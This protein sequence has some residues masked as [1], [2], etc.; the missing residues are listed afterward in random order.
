MGRLSG[1]QT[2]LLDLDGTLY[3]GS[4]VVP[5]APE[6]VR[7]L[8][9]RGLTV[10][11]TTNTDSITPAALA[12]HLA[13]LGFPAT[14]DELVT[15]V[16]VAARLLASGPQARVL[17]VAA[18]GVR[19]LLAGCLAGPDEP[20]THVLVADPS[21]GAT[22]QD[23]DAAFRAVRAG[24]EL[25]AT[26]VNRIARRD[27]GEHL[28]T[29]GWVRLLEY[30]SGQSARVLGKPS[31]A[32]FTAPLDALGRGPDTALVVGD[33]LAADVGGGQAIG[34]ATVLVRSGKGDRPQPGAEAEPDAVL[35]S[36]ADLPGLL[37]G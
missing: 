1:I 37:R 11:F 32:F 12:G 16:A 13:R 27:D 8:R 2:V 29:G 19:Q 17:A 35:D 18:D 10:R 33:D 31:P 30:A 3:V 28:D 20:V 21:Y 9:D 22:Y 7:W 26:Q 36:V 24:A 4:Q 23:L 25:V 5:G 34:A 14:Q 6:A 15:P